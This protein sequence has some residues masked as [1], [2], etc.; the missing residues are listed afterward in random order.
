[1][2]MSNVMSCWDFTLVIQLCCWESK[3][4]DN[5]TLVVQLLGSK[6]KIM[7]SERLKGLGEAKESQ[8]YLKAWGR[9]AWTEVPPAELHVRDFN[10]CYGFPG[11]PS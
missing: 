4:K 3:V 10:S 2:E 7:A 6:V 9:P 5:L 1:M 8:R 11:N